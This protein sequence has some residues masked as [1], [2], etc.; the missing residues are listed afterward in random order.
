VIRHNIDDHFD[1]GGVQSGDHFVE[2]AQ[3]AEPRINIAVIINVVA[4]VSEGGG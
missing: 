4:A 2:V 1:A 3:S